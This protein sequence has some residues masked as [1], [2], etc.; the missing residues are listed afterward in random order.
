MIRKKE[1]SVFYKCFILFLCLTQFIVGI[2]I[3]P[4]KTFASNGTSEIIM[5]VN[6]NR[7]LHQLNAEDKKYMASTTKILTA[8]VIIENCDLEEVITISKNTIGIEGS[9]I[10]LEVGE[11]LTVLRLHL[12]KVLLQVIQFTQHGLRPGP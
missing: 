8:I 12:Q 9:S 5:E 11:R 4:K 2:K 1:Y 6:S 7:V 3:L 10:Y